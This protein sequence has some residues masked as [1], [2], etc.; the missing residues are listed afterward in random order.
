[1]YATFVCFA[2]SRVFPFSVCNWQQIKTPAHIIIN[3]ADAF[4]HLDFMSSPQN[5]LK[6]MHD[7]FVAPYD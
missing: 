2:P 1:V 4:Q 6:I 5:H 7:A 3:N